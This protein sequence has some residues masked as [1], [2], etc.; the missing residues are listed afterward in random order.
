MTYT[1]WILATLWLAVLVAVY[2]RFGHIE[3]LAVLLISMV[4]VAIFGGHGRVR[5]QSQGP[6]QDQVK[7]KE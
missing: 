6:D 3:A 4:L 7:P 5:G 1:R 2:Q